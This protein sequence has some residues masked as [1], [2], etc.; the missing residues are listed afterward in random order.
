VDKLKSQPPLEELEPD[1]A[2]KDKDN[3]E[4]NNSQ[5]VSENK[6]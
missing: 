3:A 6:Y 2:V 5:T 1:N 4:Q